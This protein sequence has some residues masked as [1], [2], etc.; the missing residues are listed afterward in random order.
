MANPDAAE[1]PVSPRAELSGTTDSQ[2]ESFWR[3]LEYFAY[4]RLIVAGTFLAATVFTQE[5]LHVGTQDPRLFFWTSAVYLFVAIAHLVALAR[6]RQAFNLQL[7]VQVIGDIFFLTLLVFASGGGKSG[8]SMLLLVVLAGAGLVGQGRMVLFYAAVATL[9]LLLEQSYR[10]LAY[11]GAVEDFLRTGLTSIGF[12]GSAITARLLALR[13]VANEALARKRGLDL[14]DQLRINEQVIRDMQDGVLVID[15]AGRVRQSNPQAAQLLGLA[16]PLNAA[17]PAGAVSKSRGESADA[18]PPAP[19][20]AAC[21]PALAQEFL[22]RRQR[23][24]ESETVIQAPHSGRTLRARFLPPGEGG[25]ALI[26]LEDV[27]RQQQKAQQM[28]LAALGRLTANMAHEIRNPLAAISHAAE[29]LAEEPPSPGTE[30]LTRIIGDNTQRLNRLVAETME[31]GRRDRV[32]PEQIDMESFIRQQVEE[33]VLQDA[34]SAARIKIELP[35]KF[36]LCFDRG[37]LHR[38]IANLLSNAL[39]YASAAPGAVRILGEQ[40]KFAN[41]FSLH[42]IDDGPGIDETAKSQVFE[43]FFTTSA[44]GTGLGLYIARELC[45]ANGARLSLLENTPGAHFCLSCA[46]SCQS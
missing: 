44:T 39:R 25:N 3:P 43:P 1:H 37:H 11:Q 26:Y 35:G 15:A 34:S 20:L 30:R 38:V 2:N 21:A 6:W 17:G 23:G 10:V 7:N 24:I 18:V 19:T 46:A 29:L 27:G 8:I 31:L 16:A 9:F 36:S 41:R 33:L 4:Y 5:W 14:A 22:I 12:F 32:S 28:K 13:V 45:E 40:G 42:I